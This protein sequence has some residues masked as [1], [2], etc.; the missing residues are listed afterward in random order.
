MPS[1]TETHFP[2][3]GQLYLAQTPSLAR[4][5]IL[6][7]GRTKKELKCRTG[8]HPGALSLE[9]ST[10][11]F[12]LS[13][14]DANAAES[15]AHALFQERKHTIRARKEL[16]K[17]TL[18]EA[19]A[20]LRQAVGSA[21]VREVRVVPAPVSAGT[22]SRPRCKN[23]LVDA[24]LDMPLTLGAETCPLHVWL[25][26]ALTSPIAS[27]K[28]GRMGV[29]CV[30]WSRT[31]PRFRFENQVFQRGLAWLAGRGHF[32]PFAECVEADISWPAQGQFKL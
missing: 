13:S 32:E 9:K 20:V 7:F 25:H 2:Y 4:R 16:V 17:C 8:A 27:R 10:A 11:L 29:I 3:A 22:A 30:N 5:G 18:K 1:P 12:S 24:L 14:N 28:L 26:Q 31:A 19:Q 21:S 6:K 23:R 15:L